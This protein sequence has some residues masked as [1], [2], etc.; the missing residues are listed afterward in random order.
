MAFSLRTKFPLWLTFHA[1]KSHWRRIALFQF[2]LSRPYSIGERIYSV[3]GLAF[4]FLFGTLTVKGKG[5]F[6][7]IRTKIC[8]LNRLLRNVSFAYL[9][10]TTHATKHWKRFCLPSL[11]MCQFSWEDSLIVNLLFI[12]FLSHDIKTVPVCELRNV[13]K[14]KVSPGKSRNPQ[15]FFLWRNWGNFYHLTKASLNFR[16]ETYKESLVR[17]NQSKS[18]NFID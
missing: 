14:M 11:N 7:L 8:V 9:M 5:N 1:L 10:L 18:V 6:L 2:L 15:V 13:K 3:T 17:F 12:N 16:T 4:R